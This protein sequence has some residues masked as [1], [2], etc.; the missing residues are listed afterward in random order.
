MLNKEKESLNVDSLNITPS[1]EELFKKL[2][3]DAKNPLL[4]VIFPDFYDKFDMGNEK[5]NDA[6]NEL[7]DEFK[8][9]LKL[10]STL[11]EKQKSHSNLSGLTTAD[12]KFKEIDQLIKEF[13]NKSNPGLWATGNLVRNIAKKINQISSTKGERS[14]PETRDIYSLSYLIAYCYLL[15][16]IDIAVEDIATNKQALNFF[17]EKCFDLV[18]AFHASSSTKRLNA[19]NVAIEESIKN[20]SENKPNINMQTP[21]YSKLSSHPKNKSTDEEKINESDNT[22]FT[23]INDANKK[24]KQYKKEAIAPSLSNRFSL[25]ALSSTMPEKIG[26]NTLNATPSSFDKK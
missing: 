2:N 16:K 7:G 25:Y 17:Q 3:F 20:V 8:R 11:S 6:L 9:F 5:I 21:S 24:T 23:S 12:Q 10:S 19:V 1:I 13:S 4:N 15:K 22:F 18:L 14:I 26:D